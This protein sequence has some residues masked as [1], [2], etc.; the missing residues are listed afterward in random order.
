MW[1]PPPW[2]T[3]QCRCPWARW[4]AATPGHAGVPRPPGRRSDI[5]R[6]QH[7]SHHGARWSTAAHGHGGVPPLM[8]TLP[9]RRSWA[10]LDTRRR[11]PRCIMP[12]L[13]RFGTDRDDLLEDPNGGGLAAHRLCPTHMRSVAAATHLERRHGSLCLWRVVMVEPEPWGRPHPG[14][15][16]STAARG[17]GVIP[18]PSGRRDGLAH[19]TRLDTRRLHPIHHGTA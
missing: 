5:S 6:V 13:K 7:A 17:H 19:W 11:H 2:G 9:Y 10:R 14:A 3:L 8:G 18:P 12:R 16:W 4:S 15:R 1:V